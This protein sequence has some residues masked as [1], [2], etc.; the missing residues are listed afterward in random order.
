MCCHVSLLHWLN[1]WIT[2]CTGIYYPQCRVP[3]R[4]SIFCKRH[5]Q[6]WISRKQLLYFICDIT[7]YCYQGSKWN[8]NRA[9]ITGYLPRYKRNYLLSG[10]GNRRILTSWL[11]Q[12]LYFH[13]PVHCHLAHSIDSH[14]IY[15]HPWTLFMY[16]TLIIFQNS[17]ARFVWWQFM[18]G[19][20]LKCI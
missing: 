11:V 14:N 19:L 7:K 15:L 6:I 1:F 10:G 3:T 12:K 9:W 16:N 2:I 4:W 20:P 5:F 17:Y 18:W 8:R 13:S